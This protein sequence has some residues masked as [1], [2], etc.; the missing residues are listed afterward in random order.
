MGVHARSGHDERDGRASRPHHHAH[1]LQKQCHLRRTRLR[2]AGASPQSRSESVDEHAPSGSPINPS[3]T[4]DTASRP[5]PVCL[6]QPC[7]A[8]PVTQRVRCRVVRFA[9]NT[10]A[11]ATKSGG[12]SLCGRLACTPGSR[13]RNQLSASGSKIS[14]VRLLTHTEL[15][16]NPPEMAPLRS[17]RQRQHLG[18][19]EAAGVEV[20]PAQLLR[21]LRRD[22]EALP[23]V[24]SSSRRRNSRQSASEVGPSRGAPPCEDCS[25]RLRERV[26]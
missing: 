13:R 22:H 15:G 20:D 7:S 9:E 16:M 8:M 14:G 3:P 4:A 12:W 10:H 24:S 19:L 21:I 5:R 1:A 17:G 11:L 2:R 26:G 25:R 23:Q 18:L 6:C